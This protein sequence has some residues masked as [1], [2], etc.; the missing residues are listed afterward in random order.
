MKAI[1]TTD[2]AVIESPLTG[3]SLSEMAL[4]PSE[5]VSDQPAT[6]DRPTSRFERPKA[7]G[8]FLFLGN[9]KF[10][11]K[12]VTYGAFP[13]N[14]RGHQFPETAQVRKDFQLMRQAGINAILTYTVPDLSLLDEAQEH[15]IRV[16]V[17]IPWMGHVCFLEG[18]RNR[19]EIKK[20][21]RDAVRSLQ[22][23]PAILMHCVA[24]ELP[25]H[26]VRWHGARNVE[27][28]LEELYWVAKEEDP[29]SLVTYTNFPTTEYLELPFVDVFT[30]NVY[31]HTRNEFSAYVSRLQHLSG[32][33][34]LVLTEFGMCSFRHTEEGQGEFIHWQLE[35]VFDQGLAG[36]VVFGWTDPFF[37]DGC[38]VDEWGFGL[39]DAQRRP[40]PSYEVARRWFSQETP[41]PPDREWPKISVVVAAHNAGRTLDDCLES[42]IKLRYPDYEVIVINDGST[43]KTGAIAERYPV[44]AITTRN[45]GVSGARNEGLRA[46]TGEIIA[47]IDSDAKADP[48][49][50][51]YLASTYLKQ[52]VVG[53]GG[54]NLV[55][56]EDG[57]IAKCVYRSP[58]G[59]CQVM[60]DDR[61]AEHIP[62][63]NMSF[64]K[65]VL[66][67]IGGFDV[68]YTAAGD[69]VDICWRVLERGYQIGY[70]PSAVVWHHR[71][72]SI[73][74][75]WRQQVG[76]GMSEALLERKHPNK[77]NP[78]GHTSWSGRI[79][80]PYPFFRI[81][82]SPIVYHGLWGSA[83]FQCLYDKGG[84]G[85]LSF[86]PRAMEWH[87]FIGAMTLLGFFY[88]WTFALVGACLA[89]TIGYGVVCGKNVNLDVLL[90]VEPNANFRRRLLWRATI[91]YLH[92]L[93]PLARDWGRLKGGLT[94]WRTALGGIKPSRRGSPWWQRLAPMTRL[95]RWT[96][97][98]TMHLDKFPILNL[99]MRKLHERG[100]FVGW[101][102]TTDTW[103]L[104]VGRGALAE[105]RVSA[106]VEHHGGPRRTAKISA[107][108]RPPAL[109]QWTLM[110]MATLAAL[111]GW[112]GDLWRDSALLVLLAILWIAGIVEANRLEAVLLSAADE[113]A[114]ELMGL[115]ALTAA[116]VQ[117]PKVLE[118]SSQEK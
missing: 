72:P 90:A 84:M 39:V 1:D 115:G 43:D 108:V 61:S 19:N 109:V 11:V 105:S 113:A 80:A 51:T 3:E 34:P 89:Y 99:M 26:I 110:V 12:G 27:K 20:Q 92:I 69:D 117:E 87:F 16:I 62:G 75:Y 29:D 50:L 7:L 114:F 88:P 82:A 15:G 18:R 56:P 9:E 30:F 76:Y 68:I 100:C 96:Q 59:P 91:A 93:E 70:S 116:G 10:F 4:S 111:M 6:R 77:F 24:K 47:Y 55:P 78:W 37:Q 2:S 13:P 31:L 79:Y 8:K 81:F 28:F 64:Y 104:K 44:R 98:G 36:A 5:A 97:P 102:Q 33:R 25:P 65:R 42:L 83:G 46:A 32:E 112:M 66:E 106:V 54:P 107:L 101:N 95:V 74:A 67:E 14:S 58:G 73:R 86:L 94:P 60:F 48:D 40:K 35:E 103:D 21:V 17:N 38:L 71:R 22:Q 23:H 49:W 57:W 118:E 45:L 41:F 63:C 53:V 52:D 85:V